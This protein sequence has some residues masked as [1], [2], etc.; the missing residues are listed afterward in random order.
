METL[1]LQALEDSRP[2]L[3]LGSAWLV[4]HG[5]NVVVQWKAGWRRSIFTFFG[6]ELLRSWSAE[7]SFF[8]ERTALIV[9]LENTTAKR[10]REAFPHTCPSSLGQEAGLLCVSEPRFILAILEAF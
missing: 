2:L 5:P 6:S 8:R 7:D 10:E 4:H 3:P 9:S 1:I